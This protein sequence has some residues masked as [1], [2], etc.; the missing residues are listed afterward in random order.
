MLFVQAINPSEMLKTHLTGVIAHGQKKFYAFLDLCQYKH[1]SNMSINI[2][3]K[4][5]QKISQEKVSFISSRQ[6]FRILIVWA[7]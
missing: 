6:N 3:L 4:V 1:D 5:L 7:V 2:L